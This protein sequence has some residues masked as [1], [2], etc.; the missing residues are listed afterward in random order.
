MGGG[1]GWAFDFYLKALRGQ[2]ASGQSCAP[3]FFW[4]GGKSRNLKIDFVVVV[5]AAFKKKSLKVLR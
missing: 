3:D 5:D 4:F 1:C 2:E